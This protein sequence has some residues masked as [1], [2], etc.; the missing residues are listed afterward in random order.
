MS[1]RSAP[2]FFRAASKTLNLLSDETFNQF[3]D[4]VLVR[5]HICPYWNIAFY[6]QGYGTIAFLYSDVIDC[7]TG[8]TRPPV[9]SFALP[10]HIRSYLANFLAK[11]LW[12][13]D[14]DLVAETDN[15]P[16]N[17]T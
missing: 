17:L 2:L 9:A 10:D 14:L 1:S 7:C 15:P 12:C 8:R 16:A 6:A 11:D 5:V 4:L 3:V 13:K